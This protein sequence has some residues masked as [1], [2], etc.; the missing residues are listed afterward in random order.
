MK[1]LVFLVFLSVFLLI[2]II[3]LTF[4]LI[5]MGGHKGFVYEVYRGGEKRGT[6]RVDRYITEGKLV[7][8]SASEYASTLGYPAVSEKLFLDKRDMT[9]LKFVRETSGA[10]GGMKLNMIVQSGETA[11]VLYIDPPEY[12]ALKGFQTGGNTMV[13]SPADVMLYMPIMERY[14]FWKKG[15]QY[16]EV[17]IPVELPLPPM[18]DKAGISYIADEYVPA[19]GRRVEAESFLVKAG[20][21][22][23]ARITLSKY[24]HNILV[25]EIGELRTR[26]VLAER[27][28]SPGKRLEPLMRKLLSVKR[29]LASGEIEQEKQV[30]SAGRE[31]TGP[32]SGKEV[33]F[34][35]GN[36]IL[37]GR[38]WT[39]A[40][41]GSGAAAVLIPDD[42][43]MT[44]GES[45]LI[46]KMAEAI[47]DAGM[48][49]LVFDS[50]GQGKSQGSLQ[51]F[52][53]DKK[54]RNIKAAVDFLAKQASGSE[55]PVNLI[56]H[57]QGA[58]LALKAA[59]GDPVVSSC[60]LLNMPLSDKNGLVYS[61]V[62]EEDIQSA[63]SRRGLGPFD[64]GFMEMVAER[65]GE[66]AGNVVGSQDEFLFFLGSRVPSRE[67][68]Q[69]LA[70]EPYGEAVNSDKPVLLIFGKDDPFFEQKKADEL[71]RALASKRKEDRVVVYRGLGAYLGE[72]GEDEGSTGFYL[73]K[74]VE[75]TVVNW[76]SEKGAE[77]LTAGNETAGPVE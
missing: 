62:S 44:M 63:L 77:P 54:V 26:F 4:F 45:Y 73:D 65:A 61:G 22:P 52:D 76:I 13:L 50:P 39:P 42:G 74:D 48:T 36:L 2:L 5:D 37:S 41:A 12:L 24:G 23:E 59:Y 32:R 31:R 19:L 16:F 15:T 69:F 14:N 20:G 35:S 47:S 29:F 18:R 60:V 66:H 6:V 21:L 43:V 58:Y 38:I 10:R 64:R 25:L 3:I 40:D 56:G 49:A 7:F 11:E 53:D 67:Y 30:E 17:M 28:E 1:K 51:G 27:I 70:R 34:E 8:K 72:F 57:G 33:F 9:P 71:K 68:R 55:M 46:S 75:T